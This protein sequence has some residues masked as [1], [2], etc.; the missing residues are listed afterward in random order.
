MAHIFLTPEQQQVVAHNAGPALVFA[1]AGAG[2]TTAMVHRIARLVREGVY[3]P[4][5]ILA[6]SFSRA[7]VADIK[8]ALS[9]HSGCQDVQVATLHSIGLQILRRAV[10]AGLMPRLDLGGED[11][12]SS[13]KMLLK[14]TLGRAR[15]QCGIRA[16]LHLAGAG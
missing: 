3:Q 10:D 5:R 7:T 1:V 14:R 9:A 4:R 13:E 15:A 6:T 11:S 8:L 2:K 16:D 12:G